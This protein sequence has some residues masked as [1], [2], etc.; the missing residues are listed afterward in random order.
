M[1]T[2]TENGYLLETLMRVM[3]YSHAKSYAVRDAA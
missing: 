2:L 1:R 3:A